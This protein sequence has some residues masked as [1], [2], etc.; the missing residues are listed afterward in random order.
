M[1][2]PDRADRY[3]ANVSEAAAAGDTLLAGNRLDHHPR[4][5]FVTPALYRSEDGQH[6][7]VQEELFAPIALLETFRSQE[8]AVDSANHSRYGLA[9]RVHPANEPRPK[10]GA[11]PPNVRF[12]LVGDLGWADLGYSGSSFYETPN[13]DRLA[14]S[15]RVFTNAYAA[16]PV[17]SPTRA[18]IMAGKYPARMDT[19][20]WFGAPQPDRLNENYSRPLKPAPYLN[21]LPLEEVTL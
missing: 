5:N 3:L 19:T 21:R 7:L 15:G 17:C 16:C 4:A 2:T 9:A 8:Q 6:R 1:L 12:I 18:S 14:S 13:I 20:D 10:R 11:G